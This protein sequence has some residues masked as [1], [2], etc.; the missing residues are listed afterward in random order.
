MTGTTSLGTWLEKALKMGLFL[1]V[2]FPFILNMFLMKNQDV[3]D[4]YS[5]DKGLNKFDWVKRLEL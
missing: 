3:S 1:L 5:Y 2:E 4:V